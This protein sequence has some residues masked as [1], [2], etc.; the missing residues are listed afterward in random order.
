MAHKRRMKAYTELDNEY[1]IDFSY[2][3]STE[4]SGGFS[5]TLVDFT[6]VSITFDKVNGTCFLEH[7]SESNQEII[8]GWLEWWY[9]FERESAE[10]DERDYCKFGDI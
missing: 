2:D 4:R 10:Q 3:T 8:N 9:A 6:D 1:T 7:L 5:A